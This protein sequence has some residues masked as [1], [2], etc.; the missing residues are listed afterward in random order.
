[1]SNLS[2]QRIRQ[3]FER[4]ALTYDSAADLQRDTCKALMKELFKFASKNH[5]APIIL[6]AGCGTGYATQLLLERFPLASLF[7]LDLSQGMINQ[8]KKSTNQTECLVGDLEQLPLADDCVDIYWSSLALQWC[9]FGRAIQEAKRVLAPQGLLLLS[10]LGPSTFY[11][12]RHAFESVDLHQHTLEF[13]APVTLRTI[14]QSLG[15]TDLE[16]AQHQKTVYYPDL[17]SMLQAV[18]AI[19]ANT[20]GNGQRKGLMTASAFNKAC[21]RYESLRTP[22]GLPLSYDIIHFSA[23]A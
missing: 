14:A 10:T 20:V 18:K 22:A 21:I 16:I 15:F 9:D 23:K 4:A 19:G 11:E 12:L 3:S 13:Q 2:K 5:S 8:L 1:M 17:K 6:D 7:A